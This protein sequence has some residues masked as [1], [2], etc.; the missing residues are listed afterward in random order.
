[1]LSGRPLYV[2]EAQL[3]SWD[4][5]VAAWLP[6][7]EGGGAI[8]DVLFGDKDFV[9]RSPYTW[10]D[11]YDMTGASIPVGSANV[12]FPYG[13]GLKKGQTQYNQGLLP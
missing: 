7:P 12:I 11:A 5:F 6:G 10:K 8:A 2:T 9:G 3:D 13:Y 4:A 1:M